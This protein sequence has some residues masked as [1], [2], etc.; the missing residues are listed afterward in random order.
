MDP[1]PLITVPPPLQEAMERL[2]SVVLAEN[3]HLNLTALRTPHRCRI[4]NI[5]DSLALLAAPWAKDCGAGTTL[6]D[7]GTGG[8]F[9]LLPLAV[10]SGDWQCTGSD[11]IGK[12]LAAIERMAKELELK[13]VRTI[14]GRAE[15]IGRLPAH[16]DQHDLVTARAV[17]ELR[18]LL[19]Y[20][21]PLAKVGGMIVC[22]KSLGAEAEITAASRAVNTLGLT[23]LEP[24]RYCLSDDFG[25]R[26]LLAYR[27][28]RPTPGLFPRAVGE[29][30]RQP[31]S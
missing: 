10:V 15:E 19:E 24:F 23:A 3:A 21:A 9:P 11:S 29:A 16:R 27:K 20:M 22:W 25:E 12:K 6:F 28:T 31:L 4:G 18:V 14:Q 5:E 17:A 26:Q 7:L 2:L 13:N 8:G 1:V 30:K